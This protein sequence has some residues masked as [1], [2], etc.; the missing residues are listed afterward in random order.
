MKIGRML[1]NIIFM[2]HV[3][4]VVLLYPSIPFFI[5][6]SI[7]IALM[8]LTISIGITGITSIIPFFLASCAIGAADG[9]MFA[10]FLFHAVS[11]TDVPG[12]INLH[13]IERELVV[14]FL[15]IS[16]NL[17]RFF[18]ML[19][20]HLYFLETNPVLVYQQPK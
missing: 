5:L 11:K 9:T 10:A 1:G 18:G 12:S 4:G 15:M 3:E 7:T 14:N 6:F 13:F 8:V 17:G 20:T 19:A 2:S 16:L